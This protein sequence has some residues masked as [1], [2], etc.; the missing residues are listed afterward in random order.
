M[1]KLERKAKAETCD[2]KLLVCMFSLF[3]SSGLRKTV[4]DLSHMC[5]KLYVGAGLEF[6]LGMCVCGGEGVDFF[7]RYNKFSNS[8]WKF[9]PIH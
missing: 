8:F 1:K 7:D 2:N 3:W 5:E 6:Q 9:S 4:G